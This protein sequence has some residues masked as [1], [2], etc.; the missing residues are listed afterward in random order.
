[1]GLEDGDVRAYE[2]RDGE[3]RIWKGDRQKVPM[4]YSKAPA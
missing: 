3:A 4:K 2:I 1:M